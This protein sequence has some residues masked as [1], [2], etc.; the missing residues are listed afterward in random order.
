MRPVLVAFLSVVTTVFAAEAKPARH[1]EIDNV[2][3]FGRLYGVVRYFYSSDAAASLDW[4]RFAVNGVKRVRTCADAVELRTALNGLFEALGPGIEIGT[5]LPAPA[6]AGGAGDA[7]V[8]WRYLGPGVGGTDGPYAAKRTHRLSGPAAIDGF[9]TLMQTMPAEA[10]RGKSIRLRGQVRAS[11]QDASGT[12]ALWLRVDRQTG[13]M[14][15]FDNMDDRPIRD[16][17]WREYRIEG[18]V[19]DDAATIAFGV[20]AFGQVV[21]ADFDAVELAVR[22]PDGGWTPIPIRDAGFELAADATA[23]WMRTG[24]SRNALVSRPAGAAPEGRQFARL[25]SPAADSELFE[26]APPSAGEHVDVDLGS[27]LKA[28]VPL[29]LTDAQ[30]VP[31]DALKS[32]LETLTAAMATVPGPSETPDVDLRLADV[33]VAWNVFRHFYPYWTEAGVDWDARLRPQLEAAYS[34]QSRVAQGDALRALLADAR[35]GHGNVVDTLAH[36]ERAPLPVQFGV[37]EGQLVITASSAPSAPVGSVVSAIDGVS[38]MRR[39]SEQ[40][41]KC[42]GTTQWRQARSL[43]DLASGRKGGGTRIAV[44]GGAGAHEVSLRYDATQPVSE[45]R[46]EPVAELEPGVW[47]VDLTRAKMA[48]IA[49][50]LEKLASARG[51]VFDMRGYP[52]DAGA[53]MLPHLI[54]G[55]ETDRW[56]HVAK[57]VGPFGRFAGWQSHGWDLQPA[58]PRLT[59]KIVFL[60]DGRAISYAESVMGYVA[61]R[62][63]GTIVGA[64]TAGTNGNVATF[65]VPSGFRLGFTGMRVTGHDGRSQHHLVGIKPDVPIAP[66]LEGLRSGRDEVLGKARAFIG[67]GP[68]ADSGR[69]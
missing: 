9:V 20:M 6:A 8:A 62:K 56:M 30:A 63:L 57:V 1:R 28:R 33:V 48:E 67:N 7:L 10:V 41:D 37:V 44:D 40:M 23:G 31:E 51:V 68:N 34:A 25:A 35:D 53:Q 5:T 49:P 15:F 43:R 27:E 61:D 54:D 65:V 46:P 11:V 50:A 21:A 55:P 69:P 19:S 64:T 13:G 26:E 18:S 42:S 29:A 45:P 39:L 16:P 17:E 4:D 38:A 66:T 58:R 47:Y 22:Q 59:G 52:T 12:A 32:K 14:G 2:V 3:A 60:T 36:E 24:T